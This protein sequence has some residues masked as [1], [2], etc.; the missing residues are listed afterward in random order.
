M[1]HDMSHDIFG[2][3]SYGKLALTRMADPHPDFRLYYAGWMGAGAEHQVMK[4]SGAVFRRALRGANKGKLCIL[5]KGTNR[6][7]YLSGADVKEAK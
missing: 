7:A 4:V 3:T 1:S 5:V 2:E 6:N